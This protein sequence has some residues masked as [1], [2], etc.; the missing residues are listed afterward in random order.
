[1][2][3]WRC[4][5][6]ATGAAATQRQMWGSRQ[7]PKKKTN[8]LSVSLTYNIYLF[9]VRYVYTGSGWLTANDS[10]S[11]SLSLFHSQP[12]TIKTDAMRRDTDEKFCIQRVH[13]RY[14]LFQSLVLSYIMAEYLCQ[15]KLTHYLYCCFVLCECAR[16][17]SMCAM[18]IDLQ[19][20]HRI[21]MNMPWS[22]NELDR[23]VLTE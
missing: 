14:I 1:M 5:F 23:R 11:F 9:V 22:S 8:C 6:L 20:F 10:L 12:N 21:R 7:N 18:T 4:L 19:I 13:S 3:M 2:L 17:C 16:W 15:L